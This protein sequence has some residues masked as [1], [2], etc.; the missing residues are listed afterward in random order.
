MGDFQAFASARKHYR[1]ITH[2]IA[3]TDGLKTDCFAVPRPGSTLSTLNGT[4]SQIS[5][6]SVGQYLSQAHSGTGR[7][8]NLVSMMSLDDLNIDFIP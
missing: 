3:G 2:D 5:T 6:E 4:G 8:I 7:C 1:V